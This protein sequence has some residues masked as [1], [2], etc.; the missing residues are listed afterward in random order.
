MKYKGNPV[1]N[2]NVETVVIPRGDDRIVFLAKPV[3]SLEPFNKL[4]KEPKP[5]KRTYPEGLNKAPDLD[6]TDETYLKNLTDFY[7]K[8]NA[9]I[10][11]TSLRDSPD[12][13][14][15]TVDMSNPDT[16]LNFEK[17]LTDSQFLPAEINKI[18]E[19]VYLVNALDDRQLDEAKKYFLA[20]QA[21]V[22]H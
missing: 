2:T 4:C 8:R 5:P 9:W 11:L 6:F 22:G 3:L 16:Y 7:I 1:A 17:E 10:I 12:I 15:E 19:A 20:S 13:E 14:W 21:A 18:T